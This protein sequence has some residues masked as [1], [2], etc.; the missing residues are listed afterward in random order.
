MGLTFH[1]RGADLFTSGCE[2]LVD[3]VNCLGAHGGGLALAF[4]RRWPDACA[5]FTRSCKRGDVR[6]GAIF[7]EPCPGPAKWIVFFPTKDDWR[8]DSEL[9]FVRDGLQSLTRVIDT[10][11]IRSIAVPAL[12]C[13]IGGLRWLDVRPL[14]E[15]W[16]TTVP[17]TQVHVFEPWEALAT[18]GARIEEDL[19]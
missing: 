13:G 7:V 18:L 1:P 8:N 4:A 12:G 11:D 19:G 5:A 10:H 2:A 3:P 15:A 16:A 14:I 9:A 6:P 17:A